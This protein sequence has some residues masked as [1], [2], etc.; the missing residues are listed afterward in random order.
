MQRERAE[1]SVGDLLFHD[2]ARADEDRRRA[3]LVDRDARARDLR[4]V[5]AAELDQLAGGVDDRD[6]DAAALLAGRRSG[7]REDRICAGVVDDPAGAEV[8]HA[9]APFALSCAAQIA[10]SVVIKRV[11]PAKA[12]LTAPG[13]S[14]SS[15]S[16]PSGEKIWTPLNEE[17]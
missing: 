9:Q 8:L 12:K 5:R 6:H 13:R 7:G 10:L 4:A 15:S 16:S 11:L 1:P 14:I 3:R 17:L 2:A